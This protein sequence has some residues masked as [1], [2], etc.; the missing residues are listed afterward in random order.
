MKHTTAQAVP[1]AHQRPWWH[2]GWR[3]APPAAD[4]APQAF[5]RS[6]SIEWVLW[7]SAI[8][9]VIEAFLGVAGVWTYM[10][11]AAYLFVLAL[12]AV[13]AVLF[14]ALGMRWVA[15]GDGWLAMMRY[16]G[17]Q[18]WVRTGQLVRVQWVSRAEGGEDGDLG[19][20]YLLLHDADGRYLEVPLACLTRRATASLVAGLGQSAG[21]GLDPANSRFLIG[22][23]QARYSG[24]RTAKLRRR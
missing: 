8:G 2:V 16:R 11:A 10:P 4:L 21:S 14:P 15:G 9:A 24:R 18:A 6:G 22:E 17:L 12:F 13:I 23:L 20:A 5:G 19:V 1:A 3:V 7:C